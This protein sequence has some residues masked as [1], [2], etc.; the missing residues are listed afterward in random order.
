MKSH[1]NFTHQI[2]TTMMEKLLT[3]SWNQD[4]SQASDLNLQSSVTV[5]AGQCPR[6]S[7]NYTTQIPTL[8]SKLKSHLS[9]Y[10]T[11]SCFSTKRTNRHS[12]S[13]TKMK[14]ICNCR[15]SRWDN[16]HLNLTDTLSLPLCLKETHLESN[17]PRTNCRLYW[18]TTSIRNW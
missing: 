5:A 11:S 17:S 1:L 18:K 10:A 14:S 12:P 3:Y 7:T 15:S 2:N 8:P 9:S 16:N 13:K 4:H 6:M